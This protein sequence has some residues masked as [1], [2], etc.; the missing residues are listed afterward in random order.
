MSSGAR[1]DLRVSLLRFADEASRV[2]LSSDGRRAAVERDDEPPLVE[3]IAVATGAVERRATGWA[4]GP[5]AGDGVLIYL[6]RI[7]DR[8]FRVRTTAADRPAL[9]LEAPAG[10]WRVEAALAAKDGAAVVLASQ[11]RRWIAS[12]A[13]NELVLRATA[14][15]DTA[16]DGFAPRVALT[17][18]GD[19]LL[20]LAGKEGAFRLTALAMPDLTPAWTTALAESP[21]PAPE[22]DPAP[23]TRRSPRDVVVHVPPW[24]YRPGFLVVPSGDGH[25]VLVVGGEQIRG[26]IHW[27]QG[28]VVLDTATGAVASSR[29]FDEVGLGDVRAGAPVPGTSRVALLHVSRIPEG[30]AETWATRFGGVSRF[31]LATGGDPDVY[32]VAGASGVDR[33]VKEAAP[34]AIAVDAEGNILLAP[35]SH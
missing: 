3:V 23:G 15:M 29:R 5:P 27:P 35:G 8:R 32:R 10:R 13:R 24:G 21:R 7:D 16:P 28:L 19:R 6:E 11:D 22:P 20:A 12:I 9:E 18:D 31:D 30:A 26:G 4:L 25:R 17:S 33:E 14:E 34:S 2:L 1:A